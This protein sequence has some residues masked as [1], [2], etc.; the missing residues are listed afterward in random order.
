MFVPAGPLVPMQTPTFP[1]TLAQPSAAWVPPS[2]WRTVMC[3]IEL[4]WSAA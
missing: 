3:R 1:V 2:S 4:F